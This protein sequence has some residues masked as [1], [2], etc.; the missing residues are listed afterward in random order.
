MQVVNVHE[1]HLDLPSSDVGA[2]IDS[3]ASDRDALWPRTMW[4]AMRFDR[5]LSVG[6]VGGHGPIRYIVEEYLPGQRVRFRFSG[7]RG[8]N[9]HHW[10]EVL[11]RG[12]ATT[13]LR[14]KLEMKAEGP[15]LLSWPLV[16][17]WL[18]DA[19]VEDSL[20]VGQ[21]SL[22]VEPTVLPWSPW[23]KVLRWA[24]SGGKAR[25]HQMPNPSFHRTCAK[26]RA[27]R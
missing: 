23:V 12:A 14:H 27:G 11:P 25:P 4:P 2:L 24:V 1:R 21:L 16:F 15:A 6:A 19:C 22:G 26:S 5:P 8:F 9:G 17:R 3:L 10:F 13:V 18:H 7:P 20:A